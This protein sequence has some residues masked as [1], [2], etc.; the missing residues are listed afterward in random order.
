MCATW[1]IVLRELRLPGTKATCGFDDD[2]ERQR[3][4]AGGEEE[5]VEEQR[6]RKD[7]MAG[8]RRDGRRKE[9]NYWIWW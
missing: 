3:M 5:E 4:R 7:V 1:A 2:E 9:S 6:K 8:C